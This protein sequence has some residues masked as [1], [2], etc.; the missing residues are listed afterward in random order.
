MMTVNN[1]LK[2]QKSKLHPEVSHIYF[3]EHRNLRK[4]MNYNDSSV[5]KEGKVIG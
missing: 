3:C 1:Y 5:P 4:T 2:S